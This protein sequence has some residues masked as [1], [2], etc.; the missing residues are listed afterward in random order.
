M[1][2][3]AFG[4]TLG[5]SVCSLYL[6]GILLQPPNQP[7]RLAIMVIPNLPGTVVSDFLILVKKFRN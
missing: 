5:W 1:Q 6:I 2:Q 4:K 7:R 3:T